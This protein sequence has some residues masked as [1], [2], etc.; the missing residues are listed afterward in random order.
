MRFVKGL[1]TSVSSNATH[2]YWH[3]TMLFYLV[4]ITLGHQEKIRPNS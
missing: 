3:N 2:H 1:N 4:V